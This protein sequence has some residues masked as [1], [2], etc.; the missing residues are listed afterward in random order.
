MSITEQQRCAG[1]GKPLV[2]KSHP[3]AKVY[4]VECALESVKEV[5]EQMQA[6]NAKA[7]ASEP[8]KS[9]FGCM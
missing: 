1:C 5:R 2:G 8:P 7:S 6:S 3:N 9:D 4:H